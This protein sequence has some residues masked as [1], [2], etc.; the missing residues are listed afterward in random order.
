MP[1]ITKCTGEGCTKKDTCYRFTS[2]P[3]IYQ[4]YFKDPP[5]K[6]GECEYYWETSIK[7]T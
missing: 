1:D 4:S 3:D 6:D 2:K 7:T 5:I